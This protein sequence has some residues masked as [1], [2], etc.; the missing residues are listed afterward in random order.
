M[1]NILLILFST[2]LFEEKYI[3]QIFNYTESN[4]KTKSSHIIL[5]EHPYFFTKFLYHKMKLVLHRASMKNYFDLINKKKYNSQYIQF[6][7]LNKIE[8]YIK[9]KSIEEDSKRNSSSPLSS[10]PRIVINP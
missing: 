7:E 2:Q 3:E 5:V 6:N 4:V 9:L 10:L 1:S 8:T